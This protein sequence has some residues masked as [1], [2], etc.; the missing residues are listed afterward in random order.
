MSI[1]KETYR[2]EI[3]YIT[4]ET[5]SIYR[6]DKLNSKLRDY[7][8]FFSHP[9]NQGFEI[10]LFEKLVDNSDKT[11]AEERIFEQFARKFLDLINTITIVDGFYR[12][13]PF[14]N[15]FIRQIEESVILCIQKD[16]SGA[17]SLLIPVIEGSIRN[18]LISKKGDSAR[19]IVKM[20]D[21]SI[22]FKYMADD[23]INLQKEY[24]NTEF[25]YL[26]QTGEYF[27][28]NQEKQI[29]KKHKDYFNLWIKQLNDY[30]NNNL[31]LDTRKAEK[32]TDKFNRHNLVHGLDNIDYSFRN[33]LRL[34]NC[35]NFLSWA[36]GV[37]TKEC[38]LFAE[39]DEEKIREKWVEYF[40]ILTISESILETKAKVYGIEIKSF[41]KYIDKTLLKPLALSEIFHKQLLKV[42]DIFIK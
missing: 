42:N 12:K 32:I 8:W 23:Y 20:S 38:S 26:K 28:S 33:Y 1:T 36:F 9:Y 25:G 4:K 35:L 10:E 31:Y 5:E 39:V 7:N 27:D 18:Y 24:L 17:I 30:L 2:K 22:A 29:I 19:T 40:K 6:I 34:F 16:F 11:M 41:K 14:L 21:L 13:R 3:E 15:D 37:I